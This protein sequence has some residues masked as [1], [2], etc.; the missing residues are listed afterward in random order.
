V[1]LFY[2]DGDQNSLDTEDRTKLISTFLNRQRH[3]VIG[4]PMTV[5]AN[6]L[7]DHDDWVNVADDQDPKNV[8]HITTGPFYERTDTEL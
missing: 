8:A 2:S 5:I 6:P 4:S 7:T 1:N 3:N